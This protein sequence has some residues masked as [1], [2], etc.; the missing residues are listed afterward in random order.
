[1]CTR[2]WLKVKCRRYPGSGGETRGSGT[3]MYHFPHLQKTASPGAL[4]AGEERGEGRAIP[5]CGFETSFRILRAQQNS[6]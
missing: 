2:S 3:Q 4:R 5:P 6:G 1:M